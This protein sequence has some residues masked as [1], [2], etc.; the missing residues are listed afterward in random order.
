MAKSYLLQQCDLSAV[1]DRMLNHALEEMIEVVRP[2]RHCGLQ[3]IVAQCLERLHQLKMSREKR[4]YRLLPG[5]IAG[6]TYRR[7][8]LFLWHGGPRGNRPSLHRAQTELDPR[9]H[10]DHQLPDGMGV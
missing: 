4:T 2:A 10:V 9:F 6:I 1:I 8:I 7:P 5:L 3:P